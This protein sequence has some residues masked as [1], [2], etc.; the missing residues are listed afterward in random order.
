MAA[1]MGKRETFQYVL[2]ALIVACFFAVIILLIVKAVPE[3]NKE[4]LAIIVGA[5]ISAFTGVTGYFFGSS[6]S[7]AKKD[8][9]IAGIKTPD[10]PTV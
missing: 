10:Q 5:L 2:A 9:T 1:K 8:E 3:Q 7:S 6:M 4:S